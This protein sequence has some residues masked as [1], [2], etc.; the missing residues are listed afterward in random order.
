M[1]FVQDDQERRL[2]AAID[3]RKRAR[4]FARR[5]QEVSAE[6]RGAITQSRAASTAAVSEA[7]RSLAQRLK[8]GEDPRHFE[9]WLAENPSAAD[10]VTDA[11]ERQFAEL[12]VLLDGRD[13]AE[14][15][16]RLRALEEETARDLDAERLWC[17]DF[18]ALLQQLP[19]AGDELLIDK[20]LA[21]GAAPLRVVGEGSAEAT[22]AERA[23]ASRK[24]TVPRS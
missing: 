15:D 6:L 19:A 18:L 1:Q 2:A 12:S 24:R 11:L 4:L 13:V 3:R 23:P 20:A 17:S 14:F 22:T 7:Q 16:S 21:V 9:Q 5:N 8:E 10:A